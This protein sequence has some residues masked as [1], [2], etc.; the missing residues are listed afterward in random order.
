LAAK[1]LTLEDL[2]LEEKRVFLRVD[3]NTPV[4]P[5][6][7]ELLELSRI[8]EAA[9]TIKDLRSSRLVIASHQGRVGRSDYLPLEKH[10]VALSNALNRKVR[11]VED[12]F[13][14]SARHSIDQLQPGEAVLLDNLR[15]AAEENIDFSFEDAKDTIFVKRLVGHLDACVLDAFPTAHRSPPSIVGFVDFMPTCAGRVVAKELKSL[16]RIFSIE[17][18][19]YVTVLGGAKLSD[20]I[21]AIDALIANNRADNVLLAGMVG[22]LFLKAAGKYRAPLGDEAEK[23]LLIRARQLLDDYS[24]KF[25]LPIDVAIRENGTRKEV[26]VGDLPLTAQVMDIG[27]KTIDSYSRMI[28]GAGTVFMSG[29]A[30]AFEFDEFGSGTKELLVAMGTSFGTTIVSGG[31]LTAALHKFGIHESIDHISTAG[32]ALVQYLAGKK[33]PLI[34]ALERATDRWGNRKAE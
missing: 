23:K 4:D 3:M 30:G 8:Q 21:E 19:P 31:H 17:K 10:A 15:F 32:G 24:E 14:E 16:E 20:R 5:K 25:L 6:N 7:G 28:K 12:V 22:L 34:E 26:S 9:M 13:G 18:G 27:H 33:L 29:P 2:Q 1:L 11:F